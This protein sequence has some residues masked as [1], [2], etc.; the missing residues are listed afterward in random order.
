MFAAWRGDGNRSRASLKPLRA[1]AALFLLL[2]VGA[3]GGAAPASA[4]SNCPTQTFLRFGN[5]AYAAVSIPATV[6]VPAGSNVGSGSV[7]EPTNG[8]GCRR[9]EKS[10]QVTQAASIAAQVAVLVSGRPGTLFVIGHRCSGFA[11]PAYWDCLLQP[12]A[13]RGQQ[14][15]ATSYPS[16]PA[17]RGTLSL[18]AAIGSASYHGH[19]VTVRRIRDVQPSLAVGISD[20]PSTAFLNPRVCPYSGF[21]N[22]PRYDDL[23][24]CLQSPIWFTFS[25][26]GTSAGATVAATGDRALAPAVTGAS[27]SLVRLSVVADYVP[28]NHG[29][30]TPVGN[31]ADQVSVH[32]PSNLASGLYEAVVT[33]PRCASSS[34]GTSLYPAGSILV[35]AKQ[36]TSPGIRIVSYALTVAVIVAAILAI[37]TYRRRRRLRAQ[38]PD[39]PGGS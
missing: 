13:F 14:F 28:A 12:L 2:A 37:R 32:V 18:G 4:A 34:R 11:G 3:V 7:D 35:A 5:L 30:L 23:L 24:H 15:T 39:G 6:H 16:T 21:S 29:S 1:A 10:V 20:Q 19:R 38:A 33:C 27:I 22:L 17:P 36:K 25:P 8:N 9:Q 26:P 31:V